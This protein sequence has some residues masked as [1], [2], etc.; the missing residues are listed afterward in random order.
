MA[1]RPAT[2]PG[3]LIHVRP[4]QALPQIDGLRARR[5]GLVGEIRG[6]LE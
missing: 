6:A 1:G 4:I 2:V 5:A 3:T